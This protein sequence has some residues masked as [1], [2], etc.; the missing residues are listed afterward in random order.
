MAPRG[1]LLPALQR[2]CD[3][4][5][6]IAAVSAAVDAALALSGAPPAALLDELLDSCGDAVAAACVPRVRIAPRGTRA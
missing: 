6:G 3:D 4:G 5:D 2:L 1:R